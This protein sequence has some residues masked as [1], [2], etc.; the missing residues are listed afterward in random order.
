[1]DFAVSGG[2]H[3]GTVTGG[4]IRTRLARILA[5]PAVVVLLLLTVVAVGQI[6]D[7][8]AAQATSRSV[9]LTLAVQNLVHELQNER[10]ITAAV[11][12]GNASFK[13]EMTGARQLVDGQRQGLQRLAG[14]TDAVDERISS[15][16]A[17]LDGLGAVRAATDG[18]AAARAATFTYYTDRI[19]ALSSVDLGLELVPDEV[20]RRSVNALMA[21]Q[22]MVEATAQER[23]FLN[24][25]FSAG[26]FAEGEFVQFAAMR[27]DQQAA[28]ERFTRAADAEQRTSLDFVMGTGAARQADHFEQVALA[29]ADGRAIVV[30]P[31]SWWSGLTTVLDD[32]GGLQEHIGSQIQVRAFDLQTGAA[33]RLAALLFVVIACLAGAVYLAVLASRSITQPLAHLAAEADAVA[34]ERLPAAVSQVQ[35]GHGE[36]PPEPPV[37]VQVPSRATL[38]IQS[39]ATALDRLQTAA[40]DLAI[41]QTLQ[42]RRTVES[43]ANLGRRNQNLIR[44]QLG[45]ITSLEREEVDPQALANLFELDH[46]ATRMRRNAASLLVLVGSASHRRWSEPVPVADVIRAAVSEVEEYRRAGL[47][48]VDDALVA[49]STVGAVAHLLSE[50]IE[51]GLSF[52]PPDTEVEIQGRQLPDGYLIAITD[53]GVGMTV[54]ELAEANSRLRGEGDFIAAP[55]RYLGHYVV[56]ELARQL[57]IQVELVPSPLVGVTARVTLPAALLDFRPAVGAAPQDDHTSEAVV[58]PSLSPPGPDASQPPPLPVPSLFE[59]V[60]EQDRPAVVLPPAATIR[61]RPQ[62]DGLS[63]LHARSRP[64]GGDQAERTAAGSAGAHPQRPDQAGTPRGPRRG[65][66]GACG[67]DPTT[68]D[69][70]GCRGTPGQ[71][72]GRRTRQGR[73]PAHRTTGRSGTRTRNGHRR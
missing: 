58:L 12:G 1:M 22:E 46:L 19:T 59:P 35:G 70:P 69:R 33:Q 45:F 9:E 63:A 49:G 44:R 72:R 57:S 55:T 36:D 14:G 23:A 53:Q 51:N 26:G 65:R 6:R 68:G 15:A 41:E 67:H 61:L 64:P 40:Y 37:P 56:G 21:L 62:D 43:L 28:T 25:A 66:A 73:G 42:R 24:G 31:Q 11:L 54:E 39:V 2:R 20:L 47:R 4:T 32:L 27:A 29:A 71:R 38:E 8:R 16:L 17:Q 60:A 48:R 52:S 13:G 50:L 3:A 7:Y 5:L 30:N 18:G 34:L 10:G